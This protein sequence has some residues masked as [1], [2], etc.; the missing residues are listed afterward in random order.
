[1]R[2]KKRKRGSTLSQGP[3]TPQSFLFLQFS[4][5][6][7]FWACVHILGVFCKPQGLRPHTWSAMRIQL[8]LCSTELLHCRASPKVELKNL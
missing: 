3:I 4:I 7:K 6:S 5:L 1:M 8:P 2:G